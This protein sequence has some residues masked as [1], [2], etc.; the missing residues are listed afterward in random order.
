MNGVPDFGAAFDIPQFV[1]VVSQ[2]VRPDTL[3]VD[4]ALA[5]DDLCDLRRPRE[6]EAEERAHLVADDE[7]RVDPLRGAVT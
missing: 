1:L 7:A 5:F 2:P 6:R 3:V 4:E